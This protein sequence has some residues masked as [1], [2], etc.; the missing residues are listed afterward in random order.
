MDKKYLFQLTFFLFLTIKYI[1]SQATR[2]KIYAEGNNYPR[3]LLLDND[4]VM[5]FSGNPGRMSRYNKNAEKIYSDVEIPNYQENAAIRQYTDSTFENGTITNRFII[6]E[7]FNIKK[8]GNGTMNIYLLNEEKLIK[9][10]VFSNAGVHSFKI[11]ICILNGVDRTPLISYVKKLSDGKLKVQIQKYT[12]NSNNEFVTTGSLI[13]VD[14]TNNYI[15]CAQGEN[16]ICCQYVTGNCIETALVIKK[17]DFSQRKNVT[18][19]DAPDCPFDKVVWL[20]NDLFAFTFQKEKIIR[21]GIRSVNNEME[22]DDVT[23][24]YPAGSQILTNCIKDTMKTDA[25]RFN[26]N[27]FVISCITSE[28]KAHIEVVTLTSNGKESIDITTKSPDVDFPFVTKFS[29]DYISIFYHYNNTGEEVDGNVFE[30][31]F[32]PSC[33][34]YDAG[35]IYINSRTEK[36]SLS[37][38]VVEGTGDNEEGTLMLYFPEDITTGVL[39]I[40]GTDTII[41]KNDEKETNTEFLFTSGFQY[42]EI[43]FKFAGKRND[44]IGRYCWMVFTVKDCYKGCY[45]CSRYGEYYKNYCNGCNQTGGYYPVYDDI[46]LVEQGKEINC[47]GNGNKTYE[48]H[49]FD[50]STQTFKSCYESCKFCINE[51]TDSNHTC[52]TCNADYYKQII[53]GHEND[54]TNC[55]KKEDVPDGYYYDN[56]DKIILECDESCIT[57]KTSASNCLSCNTIE[58]YYKDE[59]NINSCVKNAP[60]SY[61][62]LDKSGT[63][64]IWKE[65]YSSCATC[66]E[67]GTSIKHNCENCKSNYYKIDN[68]PNNNCLNEVPSHYFLDKTSNTYKE[69]YVNCLTCNGIKTSSSMNCIECATNYDPIIESS[70]EC[71]NDDDVPDNYK[72]NEDSGK[73]EHCNK[74]CKKCIDFSSS[75][76]STKC[77]SKQCSD[78]YTYLSND[79]TQCELKSSTKKGYSKLPIDSS[80]ENNF[81]FQKCYEG[82]LS[83]INGSNDGCKSC[84]NDKDYYMKYENINSESFECFYHPT[85]NPLTDEEKEKDEAINYYV[86]KITEDDTVKKYL[87]VCTTGCNRCSAAG[88]IGNENCDECI[89]DYYEKIDVPKSCSNNPDGY[90]LDNNKYYNCYSTCKTCSMRGTASS[91]N[92]DECKSDMSSTD[93]VVDGKNLKHCYG[94]CT[95][96]GE[97]YDTNTQC[98]TCTSDKVYI[99]GLYCINCANKHKFHK[100]GEKQC[101]DSIPSGYYLSDTDYNTVSKCP[102]ACETCE[103]CDS[104]T[105]TNYIKCLTCSESYPISNNYYCYSNCRDV[106]TSKPYLYNKMC[107][108]NCESFYYLVSNNTNGKCE[109]CPPNKP[110]LLKGGNECKENQP[111]NSVL[112]VDENYD[113]LYEM[114]NGK[115]QTCTSV[116]DDNNNQNCITCKSPYYLRI[117]TSNC[118]ETCDD[119]VNHDNYYI[120]D[121]TNRKCIN[122]N[123]NKNIESKKTLIYHYEGSNE[124]IE[125]PTNSYIID[126]STGTIKN[127][128][129]VNCL[130]CIGIEENGN[131][132]NSKCTKCNDNYKLYNGICIENCPNEKYGIMNNECVNCKNYDEKTMY[133]VDGVCVETIPSNYILID[134]DYNYAVICPEECGKCKLDSDNNIKCTTCKTPYL[135]KYNSK[136]SI[137]SIVI[138]ELECDSYLYEDKTD[139][140]NQ[141][142][143]NCKDIGKYYL[144]GECV[145]KDET[146]NTNYYLSTIEGE[147]EYNVLKACHINCATCNEGPTSNKENCI[148]CNE[149]RGLLN[150]NCVT[151]CEPN[152]VLMNRIC[153]N[154]KE[155]KDNNGKEMYK[156]GDICINETVKNENP[157]LI[158]KDNTYNILSSCT[159]PCLDCNIDSDGNQICIT[160]INGYY[161]Q[162]NSNECLNNCNNYPYTVKNRENNICE[163]CK[164]SG[165]YFINNQCVNKEPNYLN[166]Y[167]ILTEPQNTYGVIEICDSSCETCENSANYCTKCNTGYIKH[168][169]NEHKCVIEC[170]TSFWYIDNNNNYKCSETCDSIIDSNRPNK[171]GNQCVNHC[172]NEECIFCKNNNANFIY[173]NNCVTSCPNG[174]EI[175]NDGETCKNN[176]NN[177]CSIRVEAL[178]R[179]VKIENL[180]SSTDEWIDRYL[181]S[182]NSDLIKN[183][184]ILYGRN[185]TLQ[186]FKDDYCEYESSIKNGISYVNITECKKILMNKYKLKE[187]EILFAKYDINR[188]SMVNQVNYNAYNILN[189]NELDISICGNE[190][191]L[192]KYNTDNINLQLAKELYN[193]YGVDIFNV[194]DSFFNDICFQY[195]DEFS[196]DVILNDRRNYLFQNISLCEQNCDYKGFDWETESIK[197]NCQQQMASLSNVK[198]LTQTVSSGNFNIKTKQGSIACMKCYKLVFDFK[199][200]KKNSGNFFILFFII[201]QIPAIIHFVFISGF[202]RV[203]SFL[204]Q[205]TYGLK[206]NPPLKKTTQKRNKKVKS[207]P[208]LTSS[209]T[210]NIKLNQNQNQISLNKNEQLSSILNPNDDN[211]DID[212]NEN[213][214]NSNEKNENNTS[215]NVDKI[216]EINSTKVIDSPE[217]IIK[218]HSKSAKLPI[219]TENTN[220]ENVIEIQSSRNENFISSNNLQER[221]IVNQTDEEVASFD[222]EEID[223]LELG[224]AID[225]DNRTFVY[226]LWRVTKKKLIFIKPF[227]DISVFEPFTMRIIILL[228]YIAWYFVFVCLL[229]TDK[230]FS[231]RY[232]TKKNLDLGYILSHEIGISVLSGLLASIIGFLFDYLLIM[233]YNFVALIRYEKNND[234]FLS[235]LSKQMKNYKLRVFIFLIV[236][237]IFMFFFWYYISSFCAVFPKTQWQMII[238]TIIAFIFGAIF[239]FVFVLIICGLRYIGLKYNNEICFKISKVLL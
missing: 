153:E 184:D 85:S 48:K 10:T 72:L 66:N 20:N 32:Y 11:D 60:A 51:G 89:T 67:G 162:P 187:N 155:Q 215:K 75:D 158:I 31:L 225:F 137:T 38:Y 222:D 115:C 143:I 97:A 208:N 238:I 131:I 211:D 113:Y 53:S 86:K 173:N 68:D 3:P 21:Y 235:K 79:E 107:Y 77:E 149:G 28:N 56:N 180:S 122:C 26:S 203:Y 147:I 231:K 4:D 220:H 35:E 69:C 110:Y 74:A 117:G 57:C 181:W 136:D 144:N 234:D 112:I 202:L 217:P 233:K 44:K 65:C 135:Q 119:D 179:D 223:Y 227:T 30:I 126:I 194:N 34:D 145:I 186:L 62:Y 213:N 61:Y 130:E 164:E 64:Y 226:F 199:V 114:C 94:G 91:S 228:F 175:G 96:E 42:G 99:D 120:K 188:T 161:K 121:N 23:N 19:Y 140:N 109:K 27:C 43:Y 237:I 154:C 90:Y 191:L 84:D 221:V 132:V 25:T 16:Y 150:N 54:P 166:Y 163:N 80:D 7:G 108:E 172:S 123:D 93:I 209:S 182:Y 15:S 29:D 216:S 45:T 205:F 47:Y 24:N 33:S 239:Q 58:G 168:P 13:E 39:N 159:S 49:F 105:N 92:C 46:E 141:K 83:C 189:K 59:K 146:T 178:R 111:E 138:C 190:E 22:L 139:I 95:T 171:G 232:L 76:Q 134:N 63:E 230:Y 81:Y 2:Y 206:T 229:Y 219:M 151:S 156:Y 100:L 160:C 6:V 101:L 106:D 177:K 88:T 17:N 152:R 169:F 196:H 14:T 55:Y 37:T 214:K 128:D 200:W 193:K 82:C 78:G 36:F 192:Y 170:T 157:S 197:C 70:S 174:Y 212:N 9:K 210:T 40:Y 8:G 71:Y 116:S 50:E 224:H 125:K 124:C 218:A 5:A 207:K 52:T 201:F 73:Y 18:V 102:D 118:E 1:N 198:Y 204:N 142:C 148:S 103:K 167:E 176:I 127:C 104:C 236:N 185:I 133:N 129:D 195:Y 41:Q 87:D 165:K 183:V 98:I 12:L